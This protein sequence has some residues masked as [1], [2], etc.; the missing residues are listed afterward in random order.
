MGVWKQKAKS[1]GDYE[2][3]P[4]GNHP[5]VCVA[6]VDIGVQEQEFAGEKK[7][8]RRAYFCFELVSEKSKAGNN[9]LL[10]IDLTVSL[11]EKAKLRAWVEAWRGKKIADGEEFD[12]SVL[13][14]KKCLLSVI[15]KG[16][17][18]RIQGVASMPKGMVVGE[19]THKP[20]IFSVDDIKDDT[21]D[22]PDWLPWLYGE[23]LKAHIDRRCEEVEDGNAKE[24]DPKAAARAAS[25]KDEEDAAEIF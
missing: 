4:P 6:I 15:E 5:A 3:A 18:A 20:F 17:Y 1:G 14:G 23:T 9:F 13:L 12:I 16:G 8:Q 7:Y 10:G 22:L 25:A 11:A 21:Y 19:P 24:P 2:Q